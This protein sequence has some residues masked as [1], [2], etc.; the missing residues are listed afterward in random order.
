MANNIGKKFENNWKASMSNDIFYYRLKDQAQSFGG[1]SKLRFSLKNPCD[2]FLFKSPTLFALELKSVGTSSI[3]FERTK[4]EKGVIH[5]HQIE[6]LRNFSR[7]K[8]IIAGFVLNF[9]HSDGT[10]NCYFIHINDFDTMINSLDKKSFNEKDLSKYNPIIIENR[11]KKVNYTYN[12]EK[13]ICDVYK[14]MEIEI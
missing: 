13:F 14:R 2:C 1:A 8:N 11:K 6:G 5:F 3:S 12:I 4:E 7:Y 10:E 9:R